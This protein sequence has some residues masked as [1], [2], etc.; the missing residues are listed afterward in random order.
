MMMDGF[1]DNLPFR[2]VVR[3][4]GIVSD[5]MLG[6]NVMEDGLVFDCN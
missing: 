1:M 3:R 4:V 6:F 2:R 5:L